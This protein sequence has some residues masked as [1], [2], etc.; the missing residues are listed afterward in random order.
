[1]LKES[2]RIAAV[3]AA[4]VV[5]Y[6]RLMGADE[7]GALDTLKSRRAAFDLLVADSEGQ[8]FGCVGDSLMAQFPSAVNAVRCAEA[9][10]ARVEAE[11]AA[12]PV[13]RRM[14]LRIGVNLGDVIEEGDSAFGDAV[15][16]AARLQALAKPGGILI[17]GAVHEQVHRKV[18]ARYRYV[19]ARHVKNVSEP[20]KAFEMLPPRTGALARIVPRLEWLTPRRARHAAAAALV[21]VVAIGAGVF[22]R[23]WAPPRAAARLGDMLPARD[24]DAGASI[25]V[26]PFT[27]MTG[28]PRNEYLGDGFA[29]ELGNRLSRNPQL[30]VAAR[31]STFALRGKGLEIDEIASRLGVRYVIEGS[32][33]RQGE[34]LRVSAALVDAESGASR[35]ANSYEP[36]SADLLAVESDIAAMV[37]TALELVLQPASAAVAPMP[38]EEAGRAYD[39][40]L[41][42]LAYL[43]QGKSAQSIAAAE[44]LFKRALTEQPGYARAQ[45]GLCEARVERY[46]LD[47]LAAHVAAAEQ[48]CANAEALDSN[49]LDVFL[50]VGRLRQVTGDFARAQAAYRRAV[51]L[52]PNSAESLTGLAAA[53]ADGGATE[54]AANTY[55]HAMAVQPGY[56]MAHLRYG[57]LL[58]ALGRTP[59]AIQS[60]ERAVSLAPENP[61]ALSNLGGAYL[62]MGDFVRAEEASRRSLALEPRRASYSNLASARYFLRRFD[63]AAAMYREAIA[64]APADH[65]LWGNLADAQYFGGRKADASASYR[66]A[67]DLAEGELAVIPKHWVN[68]AQA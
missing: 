18:V 68:H 28:S 43:R 11:N 48:A 13:A 23:E 42:G 2:R 62:L 47:R 8:P 5:G 21:L 9:L 40:H 41:Q 64:L 56:A 58:L 34:H 44:G 17:S 53:L 24:G 3:L 10:Q 45:A 57:N 55:L 60:Y 54:E 37:I 32:I 31:T 7:G 46:V 59:E 35:W 12:L 4:D 26:L 61:S 15:N 14:R 36:E 50:A 30:R 25:A 1:M 39:Y 19:G 6:S 29:E 51:Q 20:V 27:N 16:I 65:R 38:G 67:L 66:R 33:K 22:W 49:A 63:E 52:A